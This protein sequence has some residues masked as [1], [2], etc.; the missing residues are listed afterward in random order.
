MKEAEMQSIVG[1]I[2]KVLQH[3]QDP[4]VLEEV[5]VQAKAL[6]SRFPI[7]HAY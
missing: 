7:F 2:D 1:L 4:A 5:R 3:R 6:C